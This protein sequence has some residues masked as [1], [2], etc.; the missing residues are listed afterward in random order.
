MHSDKYAEDSDKKKKKEKKN[1][2]S[3]LRLLKTKLNFGLLQ[4]FKGKLCSV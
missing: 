1:E 3:K 4:R 2:V